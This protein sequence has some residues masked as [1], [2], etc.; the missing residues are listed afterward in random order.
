[1]FAVMIRTSSKTNAALTTEVCEDPYN[2][3][4]VEPGRRV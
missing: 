1:M 2:F 3:K 4:T